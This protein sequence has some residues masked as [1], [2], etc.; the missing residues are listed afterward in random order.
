MVFTYWTSYA[1]QTYGICS[2]CLKLNFF[3]LWFIIL[4]SLG[5][6]SFSCAQISLWLVL[7]ILCAAHLSLCDEH[8][9]LRGVLS[10]RI[11]SILLNLVFINLWKLFIMWYHFALPGSTFLHKV[12]IFHYKVQAIHYV[13]TFFIM[14]STLFIMCYLIFNMLCTFHDVVPNFYYVVCGVPFSLWHVYFTSYR[15]HFS[16]QCT[17]FIM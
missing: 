11:F 7:V 15:G 10:I 13:Y 12:Y 3:I 2:N 16:L 8:F 5:S 1:T 6:F 4:L 17:H 9:L 14:N